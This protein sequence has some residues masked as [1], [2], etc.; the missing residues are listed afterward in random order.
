[1]GGG[2]TGCGMV[3]GWLRV[4]AWWGLRDMCLPVLEV[5]IWMGMCRYCGVNIEVN[6]VRGLEAEG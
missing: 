4:C 1:M 6:R 3:S 2:I 5:S